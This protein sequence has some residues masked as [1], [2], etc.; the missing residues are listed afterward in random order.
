MSKLVYFWNTSAVRLDVLQ[1]EANSIEMCFLPFPENSWPLPPWF[2]VTSPSRK[3]CSGE[4]RLFMMVYKPHQ[5]PFTSSLLE[6]HLLFI[7]YVETSV[8]TEWKL[9][10]MD[11]L[12]YNCVFRKSCFPDIVIYVLK[13]VLII[14]NSPW[15]W[16]CSWLWEARGG[17]CCQTTRCN[18]PSHLGWQD[19]LC[20]GKI[21]GQVCKHGIP[22]LS[23][24]LYPSRSVGESGAWRDPWPPSLVTGKLLSKHHPVLPPGEIRMGWL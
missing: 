14:I 7:N 9:V 19:S 5:P 18:I 17:L 16:K 15:I 22:F 20:Q 3:Q 13:L 8:T 24:A 23:R 21:P 1:Q 2:S 6:L 4:V 11:G 12:K 10:K